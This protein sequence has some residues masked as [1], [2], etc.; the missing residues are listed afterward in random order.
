MSITLRLHGALALPDGKTRALPAA[1][2]VNLLELLGAAG[3]EAGTYSLLV[4]NG[5]LVNAQAVPDD[6]DVV[7]VYPPLGGG[8]RSSRDSTD[9]HD[10][11]DMA[12][13]HCRFSL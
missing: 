1:A 11:Q 10:K 6:G 13:A 3:L 2:G 5:Q 7:D 8:Q 9:S 12:R 4:L